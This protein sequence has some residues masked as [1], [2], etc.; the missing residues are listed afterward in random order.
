[1]SQR[2]VLII[3]IENDAFADE[4][5]TEVSR[6]LRATAERIEDGGIEATIR[7]LNGNTVGNYGI[8]YLHG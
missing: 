8:K 1:M 6:I 3:D 2:F 7:D 5:M 4:P